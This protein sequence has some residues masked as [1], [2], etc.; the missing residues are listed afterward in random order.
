MTKTSQADLD[1]AFGPGQ[2]QTAE[3][4]ARASD[5]LFVRSIDQIAEFST[6]AR[7]RKLTASEA[8]SAYGLEPLVEVGLEGAALLAHS[9]RAAGAVLRQRRQDLN[10]DVRAVAARARVPPEVVEACEAS[11]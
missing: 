11:R 2:G 10:L 1:V 8:L 9:A 6:E 3:G 7:G 5:R 4:R